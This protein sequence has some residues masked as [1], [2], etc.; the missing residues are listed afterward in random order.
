MIAANELRI[1]NWVGG[2]DD[3]S[4]YPTPMLVVEIVEDGL[5]LIAK[6]DKSKEPVIFEWQFELIN[7]I[8]LSEEIL[9]KIGFNNTILLLGDG[10][11]CSNDWHLISSTH[12][13]ITTVNLAYDY[14]DGAYESHNSEHQTEIKSLHQLQNL[15]FALT[16]Q[17]LKIEL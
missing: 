14:D 12:K 3:F 7:P 8:A 1:G 4:K 11:F 5:T 16:K 13:K 2:T 17:E 9:K 15:Y 6:E 10:S